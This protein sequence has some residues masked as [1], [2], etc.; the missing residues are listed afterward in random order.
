MKSSQVD[1]VGVGLNATDTL[2]S[3]SQFP[4]SGSKVNVRSL[5]VLPGGQVATA[6]IACRCWGLRTRYIGALGDDPAAK[7]H[8]D[9]FA[10]AGVETQIKAVPDCAS[11]HSFILLDEHGERTVLW[12]RDERLALTPEDLDRES[13]VNARALL[14]DGRDTA[15]ATTAA[16]WART[17]NIPIIAD[18]DEV[19]PGLNPLLENIDYL[20]VS[21]DFPAKLLRKVD[22]QESLPALKQ[23]FGSHM[24]AATLGT[25]GVLA[26]DGT[27]FYYASAYQVPVADTTGAGDIFHAAFIYGLLQDWGLQR[28]LDFACAAAALNCM[29]VGARGGIQPVKKIEALMASGV[30][31]PE[32]YRFR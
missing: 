3:V 15:A 28:I 10:E 32:A 25:D 11:A 24:A 5:N 26:W 20:I 13:I 1:V 21:R 18:L 14:V 22:L 9:A 23:R 16:E 31:Y 4:S 8:H 30:R 29:A 6:M 17:A 7:I 2:I 12:G 19:Y 27:Q